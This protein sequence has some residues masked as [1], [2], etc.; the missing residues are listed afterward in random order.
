[1]S[2]WLWHN[3]AGLMGQMP[4]DP[5]PPTYRAIRAID[6][7]PGMRVRMPEGRSAFEIKYVTDEPGG[8]VKL[9]AGWGSCV[10]DRGE[11]VDEEVY[12]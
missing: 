4:E 5:H 10:L 7:Q 1:M 8:R 11:L 9:D 3:T 12:E 2:D 6:V